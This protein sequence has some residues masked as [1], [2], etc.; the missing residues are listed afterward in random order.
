M[1]STMMA[2]AQTYNVRHDLMFSVMLKQRKG[3]GLTRRCAALLC[4]PSSTRLQGT[5]RRHVSANHRQQQTS[6][7]SHAFRF[8]G[9]DCEQPGAS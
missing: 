1:L 4:V 7:V 5:A 6:A 9:L 8:F 2:A 3:P